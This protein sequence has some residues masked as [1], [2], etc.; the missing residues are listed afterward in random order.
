MISQVYPYVKMHRIV[1]FKY[2]QADCTSIVYLNNA[3]K[4]FKDQLTQQ[5]LRFCAMEIKAQVHSGVSKRFLQR[6]G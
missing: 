3:V 1:H 4:K 2:V 5:V 6:A